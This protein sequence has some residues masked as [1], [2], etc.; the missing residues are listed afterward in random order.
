MALNV[1]TSNYGTS[2]FNINQCRSFRQA[3]AGGNY[4]TVL[5][6][7]S[8]ATALSGQPCSSIFIKNVGGVPIFIADH[9]FQTTAGITNI[10]SVS[11]F[12]MVLSAG[13]EYTLLGLTNVD[14]VSAAGHGAIG[15]IVYRTQYFDSNPAR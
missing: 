14:E 2:Y 13:E 4:S 8:G 11:A 9:N 10:A 15:H 5:T 3:V 7:L 6:R 12:A 1:P